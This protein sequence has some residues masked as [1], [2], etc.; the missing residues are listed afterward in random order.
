MSFEYPSTKWVVRIQLAPGFLFISQLVFGPNEM[1]IWSGHWVGLSQEH[2]FLIIHH[3]H[4]N[5][6][7]GATNEPQPHTAALPPGRPGCHGPPPRRTGTTPGTWRSTPRTRRMGGRPQGPIP[8]RGLISDMMFSWANMDGVP[9]A[10]YIRFKDR[11]RFA[12]P[13]VALGKQVLVQVQPLNASAFLPTAI[14][15]PWRDFSEPLLQPVTFA[16]SHRGLAG[17]LVRQRHDGGPVQGHHLVVHLPGGTAT[18][19]GKRCVHPSEGQHARTSARFQS[20]VLLAVC[21]RLHG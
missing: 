13:T 16:S 3:N 9:A 6:C 17:P 19:P 18:R 2:P 15:I 12:R 1:K 4:R 7:A 11:G 10:H 21:H 8:L 14:P 20:P 5:V